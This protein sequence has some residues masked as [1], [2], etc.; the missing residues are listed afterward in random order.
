[1]YVCNGVCSTRESIPVLSTTCSILLPLA[2]ACGVSLAVA[3]THTGYHPL[4]VQ[5]LAMASVAPRGT[6]SRSSH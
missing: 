4:A 3:S 6:V 2:M 5:L 1:M